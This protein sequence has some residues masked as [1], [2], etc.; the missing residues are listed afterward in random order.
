MFGCGVVRLGFTGLTSPPTASPP[1]PPPELPTSVD[2]NGI[3][4]ELHESRVVTDV[5]P[6]LS[7]DVRAEDAVASASFSLES[8]RQADCLLLASLNVQYISDLMVEHRKK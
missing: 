8:Q 7:D 6:E 3:V 4:D 1:L 2:A 5:P